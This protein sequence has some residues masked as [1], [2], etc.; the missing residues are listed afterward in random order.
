MIDRIEI[1]IS[2]TMIDRIETG[3]SKTLVDFKLLLV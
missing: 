1:E 3:I 2:R